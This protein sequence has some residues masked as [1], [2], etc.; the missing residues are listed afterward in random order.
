MFDA[1]SLLDQFL[2]AGG[3]QGQ[4]GGQRDDRGRVPARDGGSG[5]QDLMSRG[6]DFLS[7]Q[8]GGLAL[9]GLAGLLLG[10]KTGR[11]VGKTALTYGSLALVAGLAYKAYQG[12]RANQDGAPRPS[13]PA[14]DPALLQAPAGTAFDPAR[15]EGGENAFAVTLLGAMIAAAKADGH[16]DA[17]E[18]RR[19]FDK[20]AEAGLDAEAKAFL[21]DELRAPL[22]IDRVVAG[23]R[24]PEQALE[25]YA[26]S[27]LAIE[28]DLPA[29]KA[30]LDMLAARLGIEPA[31]VAEV[32]LAVREA[33][34][35]S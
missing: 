11:K 1:K 5:S 35:A 33:Q 17:D 30:Y 13:M 27:R 28:P 3:A 16:I 7:S 29:E 14:D 25:V 8:G 9:G 34:A 23:A 18:Q 32:D 26:A 24:T 10:S 4:F 21:M 19:I 2:G 22:D 12:Y 20:I 31:L 15:A 6:R